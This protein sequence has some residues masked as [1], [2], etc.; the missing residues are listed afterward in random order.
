MDDCIFCKIVSAEIK[1]E[2][3][4]ESDQVV[5]FRDIRPIAPAHVLII[6]K[7]HFESMNDLTENHKGLLGEMFLAAVKIAKDLNIAPDGYK[8]LIRTGPNGG[9]EVPHVHLHLIGGA[10]LSEGI[11]PIQS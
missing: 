5:A 7:E 6:P 1:T 4:F 8:L 3:L 2:F 9:Q 11:R 10:K